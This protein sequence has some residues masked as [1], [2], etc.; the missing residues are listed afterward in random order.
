G[1]AFIEDFNLPYFGWRKETIFNYE[2]LEYTFEFRTV[3]GQ[4]QYSDMYD[5][6]WWKNVEQNIPIGAYVMPII[7]YSDA[8]LCDHLGKTSR[9]PVFM[10]L[11]NIPL[12]RHNKVDAKILLSYIP[13]LDYCSV[14]KKT[15]PFRSA[16][17]KLFY[18]ALAAMLRPLR[19]L[20]Y[21]GIHLYVT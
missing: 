7:L 3:S 15:A 14:S 5:S 11:G 20:S 12:A 6:D 16:A 1:W 2:G 10:M 18:R 17:R 9:H 21:N 8:T 13:S 19:S 4:R